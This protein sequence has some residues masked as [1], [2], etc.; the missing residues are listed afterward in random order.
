MNY[1]AYFWMMFDNLVCNLVEISYENGEG[2]QDISELE[3]AV[4]LGV[5]DLSK[6]VKTQVDYGFLG[7]YFN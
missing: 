7:L 6:I 5:Q 3:K 4:E 2:A 1:F